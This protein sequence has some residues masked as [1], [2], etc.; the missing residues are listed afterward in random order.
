MV[1]TLDSMD[2]KQILT[3][4][5]DGLSNRKIG[6]TLDIFRNAINTYINLFKA[7]DYTYKELLHIEES[8]LKELFPSSTTIDND[9]YNELMY[10]FELV[11]QGCLHLGFSFQFHSRAY[12]TAVKTPYIYTQFVEH[13]SNK[14]YRTNFQLI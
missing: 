9:C 2:L 13:Y 12:S 7:S 5:M 3:L 10:Y 6:A 1:N 8:Q 14:N 11:N 4:H